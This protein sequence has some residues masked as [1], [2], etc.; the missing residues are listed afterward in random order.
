MLEAEFWKAEAVGDDEVDSEGYGGRAP[1][2]RSMTSYVKASLFGTRLGGSEN[3][4]VLL[5]LRGS[6]TCPRPSTGC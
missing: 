1:L 4:F 6:D 5:R 3:E 2:V